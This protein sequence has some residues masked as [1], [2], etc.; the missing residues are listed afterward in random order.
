MQNPRPPHRAEVLHAFKWSILGEAATRL[1][2]PV[3]FLVLAR[4]LTPGDFG[5]V[6]A[7]TMVIS[8]CQCIADAGLGKALV[9][10]REALDASAN[11]AFWISL[12]TSL[13]LGLTLASTA[14]MI[15]GF[16]GD[17]RIE[18]V[19]RVL[20]IQ[21]PLTG[22]AAI[23]VALLQRDFAFQELF[24]VR[25]LTAGLPALASIPMA[26]AGFGYWALVA[27]AVTGQALQCAILWWRGHWRPSL[28]MD[29][30]TTRQLV[31]FGRWTMLSAM[32]AWC[33]G[34][35]DSLV[36]ARYLGIHDMGLYRIGNTFVAMVFGLVFAPLLPVLYSLFASTGQKRDRIAASLAITA[37]AVVLVSIPAAALIALLSKPIETTLFGAGWE[38]LAPI[39]AM[40]AASQGIAWVVGANGEAYRAMGR[41]DLEA[42]TMGLSLVV[43]LV[44]YLVS[45]RYGLHAFVATRVALVI[46]GVALQAGVARLALGLPLSIWICAL[47][48]P[49]LATLAAAGAA[50][51]SGGLVS[52]ASA[53][54]VLATVFI[55]T[56]VPLIVAFDREHVSSLR[57]RLHGA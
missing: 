36:V 47:L 27:G 22:L 19:V 20:A 53:P 21:V 52:N 2:V 41:P 42:W 7:A 25:F 23:P 45:I 24:W 35:L 13:A 3:V 48:K 31:G 44:G 28:R 43:Y 50:W 37:R 30:D 46:V 29:M 33:Y 11:A 14:P 38:G 39:L 40:L 12:A 17:S 5:V 26:L 9:Q 54:L 1:I 16:F 57:K 49:V 10:R 18:A 4:L 51:A 8:L 6:A 55:A 56:Y 15:A 32:L 34:W